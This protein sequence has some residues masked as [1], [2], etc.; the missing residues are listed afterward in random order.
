MHV[1]LAIAS[2]AV[3]WSLP[4][5]PLSFPAGSIFPLAQPWQI[6]FFPSRVQPALSRNFRFLPANAGHDSPSTWT[7]QHA[8]F[9]PTEISAPPLPPF[10]SYI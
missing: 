4:T 6:C 1:E 10:G 3:T 7:R 8:I 2:L 9:S 5:T